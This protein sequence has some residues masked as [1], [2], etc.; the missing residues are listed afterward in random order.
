MMVLNPFP[1]LS[2]IGADPDDNDDVRLQKT[3]LVSSTLMMGSLGIIWGCIY[4]FLGNT[5]AA[6]IPLGYS[7][8]SFASLITFA[9]T[10]QYQFFRFS[11][12]LLA[13]LLPFLLMV[14]LG[15]F[16]NS[17]AV[18]LWSLMS[19]L[20]ALVFLDRRKAIHWF[21]AYIVLVGS[22]L[23]I[24]PFV[25]S[26]DPLPPAV[27]ILF[28]VLNIG[29]VSTVSFVLLQ[30]FV[31]QKEQTLTLLSRERAKSERLL[32]NVLPEEI[33]VLLK[34]KVRTIADHFDAVSILFADIVGF[35]HLSAEMAPMEMV[36]LLDETFSHFDSLVE[37]YGLE[38]I[39]TIGDNYMV[40]AGA[41]I[42][43]ADH[44]QVMAHLAL[45]M[46]DFANKDDF[47]LQFRIGINSGPVV[48]G[49]IGVSKFHY[50]IWGDPVN[51]AS[52]MESHGVPG[53][54]QITRDTYELVKEEFVC[55]RRGRIDIKGKGQMETWFIEDRLNQ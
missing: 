33:A 21:L 28:F 22:G 52:R 18:V 55:K 39:R 11:Q 32:L 7:F 16:V 27:V 49:V 37:K 43:R 20:G 48:A 40:A 30:Y 44:A 50:D 34:D 31:G 54:I 25:N 8:L 46:I 15:G 45:E 17:S 5:L 24:S 4:L 23:I 6:V 47:P 42:Q 14:A 41:P 3:L 36:S 53:K 19:P 38:K 29:G 26:V 10:R 35:T 9:F 12:L 1:Y 2:K 13:L 51:I